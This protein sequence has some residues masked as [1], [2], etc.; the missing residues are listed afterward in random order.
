[1]K[2]I[3][4][5]TSTIIDVTPTGVKGHNGDSLY[6][7]SDKVIFTESDLDFVTA[8]EFS[9]LISDILLKYSDDKDILAEIA[10]KQGFIN[11]VR[12]QRLKK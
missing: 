4:K 1:M 3:V 2:A 6:I 11:G 12:W 5:C 7:T 10:F 9:E 8:R